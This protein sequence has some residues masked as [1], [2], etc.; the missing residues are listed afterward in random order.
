MS[1]DLEAR[2]AALEQ[3][4]SRVYDEREIEKLMTRYSST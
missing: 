4:L 2:L 3:K 1:A